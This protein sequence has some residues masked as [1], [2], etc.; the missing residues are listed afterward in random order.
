M[1]ERST[2]TVTGVCVLAEEASL[3]EAANVGTL[4][5]GKLDENRIPNGI[6]WQS[7]TS[8]AMPHEPGQYHLLHG[9]A[10]LMVLHRRA[11]TALP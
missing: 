9:R 11:Y 10:R 2:Q 3:R 5:Y 4:M 1:H 7:G 8:A 6:S